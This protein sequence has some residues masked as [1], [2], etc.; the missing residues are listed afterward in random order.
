ML[1]ALRRLL[2]CHHDYQRSGV[3]LLATTITAG[4]LQNLPI[5]IMI[6]SAAAAPCDVLPQMQARHETP[7]SAEHV[8]EG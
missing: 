2:A 7:P 4:Q 1:P 8:A 5:R 6:G 3:Y